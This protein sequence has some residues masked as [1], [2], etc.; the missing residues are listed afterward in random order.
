ME[1]RTYKSNIRHERDWT[2]IVLGII[3]VVALLG[4]IISAHTLG[5][6]LQ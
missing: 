6:K 4:I 3:L 1:K 5:V 2:N